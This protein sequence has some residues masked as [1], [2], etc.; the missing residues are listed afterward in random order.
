MHGAV[1][2]L[3]ATHGIA[4]KPAQA[5]SNALKHAHRVLSVHVR[6]A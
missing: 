3:Q 1:S 2:I 5:Q 4:T 6:A